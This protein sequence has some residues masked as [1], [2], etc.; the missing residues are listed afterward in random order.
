M[1][2]FN[3]GM[4]RQQII[5]A[6]TKGLN[7][8]TQSDLNTILENYASSS[9]LSAETL[10]RESADS[11]H[12]AALANLIDNGAKNLLPMTHAAGSSTKN[13]VTCTWDPDAGTMTLT[14]SHAAA[15]STAIFEFYDGS[16]SNQKVIPAG[17]YHLSGV[18][19]GGSTSTFRAALTDI[20]G[21]VDTG[22]GADFT[23]SSP[24]YVAYRILISNACDF[25]G[26]VVLRPM[27]C[28]K[29]AWDISDK[30]VP[31]VPSNAELYA[32]IQ[33]L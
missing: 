15:D 25:T 30:F 21:A 5:Q 31:Y 1:S 26:G 32:M 33:N 11:K 9:D 13:G 22:N 17:T 20:S 10:A 18:P 14:G 29:A 24:H 3:T 19:T 6:L 7:A 16:A 28:A 4:T 12:I 2:N 8:I 23:L 27:I